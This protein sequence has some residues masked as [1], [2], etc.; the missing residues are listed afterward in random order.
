MNQPLLSDLFR[1]GGLC[2]SLDYSEDITI[3]AHF[4]L[5]Q[6]EGEVPAYHYALYTDDTL[7]Q[8]DGVVVARREDLTVFRT[9]TGEARL[10][11]VKGNPEPHSCYR[12]LSATHA[13]TVLLQNRME[14]L[15]ID[16]F[17]TSLLAL[18]KK[19][20]ELDSLILHCNYLQYQG[21]AILF[22]GPSGI[23]KS[24][25]AELWVK[26][27]NGRVINGDRALLRKVEGVWT[28]CGW[29]VCGSSEIC[30]PV[31]TPIHAVVMLRQGQENT[32]TRLSPMQAFTQL[33]TQITVNGW[34]P[35]AGRKAISL[36]EEIVTSLP[37][38]QLTCT[39]SE[40][41]VSC[42]E[43]AVFN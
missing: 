38:Y 13:E 2:F 24:T 15:S 33:Y 8:P 11:G 14:N 6:T 21:K 34:D 19:M 20:L 3:P 43:N 41:A 12:E 29:P 31:D 39:I 26:Y 28:A 32:V 40:E 1:I 42:L 16:P 17:F 35:Q 30:H 5:F 37:V 4:R 7:P 22:S 9:E 10:L 36:V 27:R 23:G 18:E 25:Q